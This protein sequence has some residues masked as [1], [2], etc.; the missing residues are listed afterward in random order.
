MTHILL[1]SYE[2]GKGG[3]VK[4]CEHSKFSV[5]F[6]QDVNRCEAEVALMK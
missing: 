5:Y 2:E 6:S 1:G 4:S 3:Y